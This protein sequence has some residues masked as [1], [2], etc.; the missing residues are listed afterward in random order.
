MVL[1]IKNLMC[2]VSGSLFFVN[3]LSCSSQRLCFQAKLN[4]CRVS[5]FEMCIVSDT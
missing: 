3:E 5:G 1:L 4:L 2:L